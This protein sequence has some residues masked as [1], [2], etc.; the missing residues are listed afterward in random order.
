[1]CVCVFFSPCVCFTMFNAARQCYGRPDADMSWSTGGRTLISRIRDTLEGS[2]SVDYHIKLLILNL[3]LSRNYSDCWTETQQPVLLS[4]VQ[5][6][7]LFLPFYTFS[8]SSPR[9]GW[10]IRCEFSYFWPEHHSFL[11]LCPYSCP[12]FANF[13]PQWGL[14]NHSIRSAFQEMRNV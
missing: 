4:W 3:N 2:F 14:S 13:L 5:L 10:I 8:D 11:A 9:A 7:F 12:F 1:M 6:G